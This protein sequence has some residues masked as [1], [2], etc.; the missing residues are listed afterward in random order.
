MQT[1]HAHHSAINSTANC[2]VA[3]CSKCAANCKTQ[4]SQCTQAQTILFDTCCQWENQTETL[5]AP[6]CAGSQGEDLDSECSHLK[7]TS[8]L[9]PPVRMTG[10]LQGGWEALKPTPVTPNWQQCATHNHPL[11]SGNIVTYTTSNNKHIADTH[12]V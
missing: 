11:N 5:P 2:H 7:L 9:H 4:M 1:C 6:G 3:Q 8:C 10:T 12:R